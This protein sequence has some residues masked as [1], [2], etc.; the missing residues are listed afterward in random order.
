MDNDFMSYV[1]SH[2]TYVNY[3]INKGI[4]DSYAVSMESQTIWITINTESKEE[5]DKYISKSPLYKY[6]TYVIEDLLVYDSQYYR[7][8]SLQLN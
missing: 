2:R 7:L 6:W 5:A 4:I 3:L 8:P 1:P